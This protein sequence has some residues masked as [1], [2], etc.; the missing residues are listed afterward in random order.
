MQ[1][2]K[3]LDAARGQSCALCGN[4]DGTVVAAHYS[5]LYSSALGKGM[6]QKAWDVCAAHL[7]HRCHTDLDGYCHSDYYSNGNANT[8]FNTNTNVN[9]NTDVNSNTITFTIVTRYLLW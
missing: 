6:G 8:N 3:L 4:D 9:A 1:S 5:G 2:R 7:C